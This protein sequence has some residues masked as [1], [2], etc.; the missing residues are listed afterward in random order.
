MLADISHRTVAVGDDLIP[1]QISLTSPPIKTLLG[2]L[3]A[4][5]L[6]LNVVIHDR[7]YVTKIETS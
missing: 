7:S 6:K 3:A 2:A 4:Y 1:P 5:I